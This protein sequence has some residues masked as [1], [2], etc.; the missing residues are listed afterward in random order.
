M[1]KT[2]GERLIKDTYM[3]IESSLGPFTGYVDRVFRLELKAV[4]NHRQFVGVAAVFSDATTAKFF[5]VKWLLYYTYINPTKTVVASDI[6]VLRPAV[7]YCIGLAAEYADRIRAA[8]S[9]E[10]ARF[11]LDN[12]EYP[13][14]E[15]A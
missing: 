2:A 10:D 7:L 4:K 8:I 15:W 1:T 14:N 11:F 9:E 6:L 12:L 3:A 13:F 5:I